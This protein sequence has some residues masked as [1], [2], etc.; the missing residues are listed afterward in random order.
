MTYLGTRIFNVSPPN[1]PS[2]VHFY[3]D[4][5]E[6]PFFV[7]STIRCASSGFLSFLWGYDLLPTVFFGLI[8]RKFDLLWHMNCQMWLTNS[9]AGWV[10]NTFWKALWFC[11]CKITEKKPFTEDNV[12]VRLGNIESLSMSHTPFL[13]SNWTFGLAPQSCLKYLVFQPSQ[14]DWVPLKNSYFGSFLA[15]QCNWQVC[16]DVLYKESFLNQQV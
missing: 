3:R 8:S 6:W 1:P 14:N 4:F 11:W 10:L 9:A 5:H 16:N 7:P 13:I 12:S 15:F 2:G